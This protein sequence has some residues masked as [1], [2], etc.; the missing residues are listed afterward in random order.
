MKNRSDLSKYL[1]YIYY[2][3]ILQNYKVVN[4]LWRNY[5]NIYW[6][7]LLLLIKI[8]NYILEELLNQKTLLRIT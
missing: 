3:L 8:S 2:Y 7:K 1:W 5:N 6:N 4:N